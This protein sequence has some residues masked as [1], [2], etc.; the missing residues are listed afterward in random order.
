M[1]SIN[2]IQQDSLTTLPVDKL[3][4]S[5]LEKGII[6]TYF[7]TNETKNTNMLANVKPILIASLAFVIMQV[8]E[9]NL[10]IETKLN[11]KSLLIVFAV[12]LCIFVLIYFIIKYA[13]N[14]IM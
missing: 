6:K 8:K 5:D 2:P 1:Q 12:K 3:E 14:S 10:F 11:G 7:S 4:P 13:V 9:V